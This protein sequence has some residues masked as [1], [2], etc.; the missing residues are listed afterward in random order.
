M[1]INYRN[2]ENWKALLDKWPIMI[3]KFNYIYIVL[4]LD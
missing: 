4:N 2:V 1:Y 3:V